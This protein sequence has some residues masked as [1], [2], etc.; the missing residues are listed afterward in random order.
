M[1]EE[2]LWKIPVFALFGG[3]V[4]GLVYA[5]LNYNVAKI[6]ALDA[7]KLIIYMMTIGTGLVCL[8]AIGL[9]GAEQ[10]ARREASGASLTLPQPSG[11]R[12]GNEDGTRVRTRRA[13]GPRPHGAASI[14]GHA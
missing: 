10:T 11:G 14:S 5:F 12:S 9:K 2:G 8:L 3:L 1:S 7:T 13:E 4:G 6:D